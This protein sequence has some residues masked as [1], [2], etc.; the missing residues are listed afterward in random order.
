[1]SKTQTLKNKHSLGVALA[2]VTIE[3]YAMAVIDYIWVITIYVICAFILA[4]TVDGHIFEKFEPEKAK[5][6]LSIVLFS[7]ILLQLCVQGFIA[8]LLIILL[9]RLPSP[10]N[11]YFGYHTHSSLGTL[12]R[13]PAIISVILFSLSTS[14]RA[15]LI[16]LYS[17]YIKSDVAEPYTESPL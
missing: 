17:R 16:T 7:K 3:Q 6:N 4:V 10:V 14:L 5:S 2:I 13:N 9:H 1:M 11:G 12:V 15:R 8:I